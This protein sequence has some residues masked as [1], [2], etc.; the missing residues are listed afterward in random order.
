[1]YTHTGLLQCLWV[2]VML[3]LSEVHWYVAATTGV[4]TQPLYCLGKLHTSRCK[5]CLCTQLCRGSQGPGSFTPFHPRMTCFLPI[6]HAILIGIP[7]I[8]TSCRLSF[9]SAWLL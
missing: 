5:L 1:M 3:A 2:L 7:C 6:K 9:S 4:S 8:T